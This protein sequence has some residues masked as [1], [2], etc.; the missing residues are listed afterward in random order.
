MN[1]LVKAKIRG[2]A[3]AAIVECLLYKDILKYKC[4]ST[5]LC[6]LAYCHSAEKYE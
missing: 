6:V 1:V 2:V 4:H 3:I 5:E